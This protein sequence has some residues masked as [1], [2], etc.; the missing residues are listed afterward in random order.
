MVLFHRKKKPKLY[1][2]RTACSLSL[3]MHN[4]VLIY[5]LE[6][7]LAVRNVFL[8]CGTLP[9]NPLLIFFGFFLPSSMPFIQKLE[10]KGIIAITN[11]SLVKVH[12]KN[13]GVQSA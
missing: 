12:G 5:T 1:I 11:K 2:F 3:I 13:E 6:N 10:F 9:R 4:I 8:F 7:Y